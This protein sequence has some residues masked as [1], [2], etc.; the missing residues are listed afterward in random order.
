MLFEHNIHRY[1]YKY[2]EINNI[3][4][5]LPSIANLKCTPSDG[6]MYP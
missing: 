3:Q 6:Q 4:I 2:L 5:F 1:V